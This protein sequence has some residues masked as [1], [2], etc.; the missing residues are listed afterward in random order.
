MYTDHQLMT[1]GTAG[2]LKNLY[3]SLIRLL[4]KR[5]IFI[6]IQWAGNPLTLYVKQLLSTGVIPVK[7]ILQWKPLEL[8]NIVNLYLNF[9]HGREQF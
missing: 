2:V 4:H 9:A 1:V 6:E 5:E 7:D 3:Q 8:L